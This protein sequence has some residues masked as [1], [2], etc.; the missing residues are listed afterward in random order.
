MKGYTELGLLLR[1]YAMNAIRKTHIHRMAMWRECGQLETDT[2]PHSKNA[3]SG[4]KERPTRMANTSSDESL[5]S[6]KT[7][8]SIMAARQ[9]C[10]VHNRKTPIT[11]PARTNGFLKNIEVE[12]VPAPTTEK[13]IGKF[14]HSPRHATVMTTMQQQST[15]NHC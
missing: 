9:I 1:T 3:T 15:M 4:P 5:A 7:Q 2:K 11:K 13:A 14:P 6:S 10:V 12:I 8:S